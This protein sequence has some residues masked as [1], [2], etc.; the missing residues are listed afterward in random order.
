MG[1]LNVT[2]YKQRLV[3]ALIENPEFSIH[4]LPINETEQTPSTLLETATS[5]PLISESNTFICV[6]IHSNETTWWC[7]GDIA[8]KRV[9][10]LEDVRVVL[11][12]RYVEHLGPET[13]DNNL[14]SSWAN[15]CVCLPQYCCFR[16]SGNEQNNFTSIVFPIFAALRNRPTLIGE[17]KRSSGVI[18]RD[19]EYA[20]FLK[21]EDLAKQYL[22]EWRAG[23]RLDAENSSYLEIHLNLSL[24]NSLFI[25]QN[26]YQ[27]LREI[28]DL[29][30]PP[31][32]RQQVSEVLHNLVLSNPAELNDWRGVQSTYSEERLS[33][34]SN[35]FDVQTI[36]SLES[37]VLATLDEFLS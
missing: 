2:Q 29:N 17:I 28:R 13:T 8:K 31:S 9:V 36:Q 12:D 3:E 11:G 35:F 7:F 24:G 25:L 15:S 1:A 34:F 19:F 37:L 20:L 14:K 16:H 21:K 18:R 4:S 27:K 22:D 30:V 5:L 26:D 10:E 32:I 23:N 6:P 33:Y